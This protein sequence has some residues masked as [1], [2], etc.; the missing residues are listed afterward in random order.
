MKFKITRT[1]IKEFKSEQDALDFELSVRSLEEGEKISID[2]I[3][4]L[5]EERK[6][7]LI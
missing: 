2:Y 1:Y 7:G 3:D 5:E 4:L 6:A